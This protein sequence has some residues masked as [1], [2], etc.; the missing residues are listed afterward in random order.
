MEGE[1]MKRMTLR[2]IRSDCLIKN[3]SFGAATRAAAVA[4]VVAFMASAAPAAEISGAGATFPYPIYAKWAEAY[5]QKTG[6]QLNYQSIGSGGGIRQIKSKT[7]TFGASD[8]PLTPDELKQAGLVQ[9]PMIMGGVVP[10]LNVEGIEAGKLKLDGKTLAD[11]FRGEIASWNDDRIAALNPD[12]KLPDTAIAVVHRSDGSGTTFLFT[13]YLSEANPDWKEQVGADAS[14]QWPVGIGAKGNEGVA[15]NVQRTGGAIG[16]VEYAY[17]L[18]NNLP[19]VLMVNQ[20]GKAV[21]PTSESFQAA[22][23]HADWAHADGF[24]VILTDQPG[25]DSWPIT[26]ASFILMYEQPQDPQASLEALKFFAWSY[27][28]GNAMAEELHYVPMPDKVVGL[29]EQMWKERI[30]GAGG[31]AVWTEASAQ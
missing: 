4:G 31:Q 18:Q 11:I 19:Y 28:N 14:V 26:G 6:N 12:V 13:N 3:V 29:V 22:A 17:A 20:A 15:N 5:Q 21:A 7:V 9:F 23:S 10:V 27:A 16:Y 24:Y 1:P 30:K 2:A 25:D 8:K